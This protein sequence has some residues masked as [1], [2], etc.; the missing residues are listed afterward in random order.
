MIYTGLYEA[1]LREHFIAFGAPYICAKPGIDA[2]DLAHSTVRQALDLASF[3]N[4]PTD[5]VVRE[6]QEALTSNCLIWETGEGAE[7]RSLM[8][9]LKELCLEPA[10]KLIQTV[11]DMMPTP[12]EIQLLLHNDPDGLWS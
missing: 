5:Q 8:I 10:R 2:M 4:K 7:F 3:N 12:N 11:V 6:I 9:E 1:Q